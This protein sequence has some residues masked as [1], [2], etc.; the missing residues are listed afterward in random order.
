MSANIS[1]TSPNELDFGDPID[2]SDEEK[3]ESKES[4]KK[5]EFI[6]KLK[7]STLSETKIDNL[8]NEIMETNFLKYIIINTVSYD[9]KNWNEC[10]D[11]NR[12]CLQSLITNSSWKQFINAVSKK[13]YFKDIETKLSICLYE[14]K[15]QIV[16][17]PELVFN[18]IN[19]LD[20]N[21][22]KVVILGQDPYFNAKKFGK[23]NIPQACGFSFSV[24]YGYQKPPSLSNIY[25]NLLQFGHIKE[26]PSNGCLLGWIMQGCLMINAALTTVQGQVGAHQA[27]WK[28]FACD[29]IN[30]LEAKCKNIVF[31]AWGAKA[32]EIC[33]NID[34]NKNCLIVSSHPSGLSATKNMSAYNFKAREKLSFEPFMTIDHFGRINTYL[35]E[36]GKKGIYWDIIDF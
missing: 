21:K 16:P 25:K 20:I 7:T 32:Y 14:K 1:E 31:V 3:E 8:K 6:S 34:R 27:M 12:V 17:Y 30:Y 13:P 29:L 5:K 36:H 15:N 11:D 10:F 23:V 2:D 28:G 24:P 4:K 35:K 33:Q 18:A 26:I 22:I 19:L 9:F